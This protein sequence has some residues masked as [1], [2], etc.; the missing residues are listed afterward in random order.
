MIKL[1]DYVIRSVADLGVGH[2]FLLPGGGCMHLVDAV[3]RE[4]RLEFV[5]NLHEQPCAIAAEAYAQFTNQLGVA[6]VTTGPGGTNTVTGVAAAWLDSTP[7]LFLSGQVKRADSKAEFGVRQMGFQEIDITRIVEPITKYAVTVTDPLSIRF[8]LERAVHLARTGRPGPVWVDIPLDVQATIIEEEALSGFTP[9]PE[10]Q[11]VPVDE[12]RQAIHLLNSAA[13]PV[14]L[15]GNGIRLAGA[16][17]ELLALADSLQ[18]PLLLS[19]KALDFVADNHPLYAGRPGMV[20]SRGANF[21]L[22]NSDLLI[23][24]GARLDFGQT[25]YDRESFARSAR[26]IFVDIDAAELGKFPWPVDVAIQSDAAAFL[27][28]FLDQLPNV[29]RSDRSAWLRRCLAWKRDYPIVLPEYWNERGAVNNYVLIQTLSEEMQEGDVLAPG[30][31]GACSEI[32]MQ[33][34]AVKRGMRVLNSEGLGPMGFG[35]AAS[36]GACIASG[37]RRTV[38]ID[39]DG[40]FHMNSQELETV[41][42]LDLPIKFFVLN[43]NGYGS[44]RTTQRSYFEGRLVGSDPSG[45]LTL[46]DTLK[47]AAAYGVPSARIDD[48]TN[49]AERV[50]EV[51][52]TSGPVICEVRVTQNQF[53]APRVA[54]RQLPD[55]TMVSSPL[56]DLWP[57]LDRDELQANMI[58]ALVTR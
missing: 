57:F 35:I 26:K 11:R 22:Q 51:L 1:A 46:P 24:I 40:G 37:R 6:L 3:G 13:R 12:V 31:S 50:R 10:V 47:I 49:L 16:V 42:R 19:W 23:S 5:C 48:H 4:T 2:I 29:Q 18:I 53:T 45:G 43:N 27:R 55:G 14:I 36:I 21:T 7:C 56:E 9:E 28:E 30:S 33:A 54:S 34:F 17:P 32:T 58:D 41:R 25:G 52:E 44:I 38:S 8:H 39:G 15:A 20:A